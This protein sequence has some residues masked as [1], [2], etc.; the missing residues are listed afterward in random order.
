MNRN[1]VL[2]GVGI[3][4][5]QCRGELYILT[6]GVAGSVQPRVTVET[7]GFDDQGIAIPFSDGRSIP[8]SWQVSRPLEIRTCRNPGMPGVLFKQ[9]GDGIV[10]LE[11]LD[12][13]RRVDVP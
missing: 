5:K 13:V 2:D 11:H 3:R 7:R 4:P 9:E 1:G 12:A 6:M 8:G 10:V